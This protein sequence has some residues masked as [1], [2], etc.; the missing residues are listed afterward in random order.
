MDSNCLW[1]WEEEDRLQPVGEALELGVTLAV[2]QVP[3]T[4][5]RVVGPQEEAEADPLFSL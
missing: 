5:A 1:W 2:E 4:V 3:A